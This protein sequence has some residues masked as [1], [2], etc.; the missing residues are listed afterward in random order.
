MISNVVCRKQEV[1]SHIRGLYFP[2]WMRVVFMTFFKYNI[3]KPT[4]SV[5]KCKATYENEQNICWVPSNMM[6]YKIVNRTRIQIGILCCIFLTSSIIQL[7]ITISWFFF[8]KIWL[9]EN[10]L[11]TYYKNNTGRRKMTWHWIF[12]PRV[13]KTDLYTSTVAKS[14]ISY[15][16]KFRFFILLLFM[17]L[18]LTN[19][20]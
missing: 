10:T 19:K 11:F 3:T 8:I 16:F 15:C 9:I 14:L 2:K 18:R 13:L 12:C 6:V 17:L 1:Y 7:C 5:M 4:I 20:C